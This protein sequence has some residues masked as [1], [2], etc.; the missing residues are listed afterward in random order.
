[1][2]VFSWGRIGGVGE[3]HGVLE[4]IELLFMFV[5]GETTDSAWQSGSAFMILSW[6]VMVGLVVSLCWNCTVLHKRSLLVPFT[7]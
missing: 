7:W 4:V 6:C 2:W 1:M 5:V 3:L